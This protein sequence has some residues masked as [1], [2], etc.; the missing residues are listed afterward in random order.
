[1]ARSHVG[2]CGKVCL[3]CAIFIATTTGDNSKKDKLISEVTQIKG[4]KLKASQIKCWG[5]SSPDRSCLNDDCHF[6]QC[7][8]DRG[9]EFCYRCSK[10]SCKKLHEFYDSNPAPREN[11]RQ[12]CKIGVEAF[13]VEINKRRD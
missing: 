5:C 8:H 10:F 7:A 13:F 1:M 12:I 4:K 6:R 3:N 2:V 11:L 9:L